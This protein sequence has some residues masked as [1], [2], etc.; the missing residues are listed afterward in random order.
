MRMNGQNEVTT[1]VAEKGT[2]TDVEEKRKYGN[3]KLK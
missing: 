3:E 2:N 1:K